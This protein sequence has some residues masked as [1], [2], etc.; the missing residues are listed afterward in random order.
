MNSF[1]IVGN[2]GDR[3]RQKTLVAIVQQGDNETTIIVSEMFE[4]LVG[5]FNRRAALQYDID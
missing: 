5:S 1:A 2:A 4:A 3:A